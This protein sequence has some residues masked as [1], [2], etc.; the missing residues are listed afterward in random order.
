MLSSVSA[1]NK[2]SEDEEEKEAAEEEE[3]RRRGEGY[4]PSPEV[5][6][7]LPRSVYDVAVRRREL[8]R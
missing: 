3:K 1:Q 6:S 5:A 4:R 7:S 8:R 2:T